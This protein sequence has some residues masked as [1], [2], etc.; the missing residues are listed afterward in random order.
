MNESATQ[1]SFLYRFWYTCRYI[2]YDCDANEAINGSIS[3]L[4]NKE[5]DLI[6]SRHFPIIKT[7]FF[8]EIKR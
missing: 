6:I 1:E 3:V 5:P 4:Q 8:L 7:F 2:C